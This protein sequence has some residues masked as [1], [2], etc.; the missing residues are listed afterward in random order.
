MHQVFACAR[1]QSAS[2]LRV[3]C[4]GA[5][6]HEGRLLSMRRCCRGSR[7]CAQRPGLCFRDGGH[8]RHAERRVVSSLPGASFASFASR[9]ARAAFAASRPAL[10]DF[11]GVVRSITTDLVGS[12]AIALYLVQFDIPVVH[13][14]GRYWAKHRLSDAALRTALR[15]GAVESKGE[16]DAR[17]LRPL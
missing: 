10:V 11:E 7:A 4:S 16:P 12:I 1:F 6:V 8:R 2:E 5:D 14:N 9:S 13:L 15:D 3:F 17:R